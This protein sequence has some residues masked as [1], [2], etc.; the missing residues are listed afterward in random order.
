MNGGGAVV[1]VHGFLGA[2][3]DFDAMR[4]FL[5]GVRFHAVDLLAFRGRDVASLAD[6]LATVARD[7]G[8]GA[9]VGYSLG[10]RIALSLAASGRDGGAPCIALSA[11]PGLRDPGERSRRAADDDRLAALLRREGL[12]PF[13]ERWYAQPLFASLREHPDFPLIRDRRRRGDPSAWADLLAGC[14]P[15]RT[16]PAWDALPGLGG[17]LVVIAGERDAKYRD[18]AAEIGRHAPAARIE[19]IPEAGHALHLERPDALAAVLRPLL[20]A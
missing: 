20:T 6:E 1:L 10:G 12:G 14:S 8:A 9:I 11:H 5:P 17:R 7:V 19:V 18:L 15:G 13:I 16:P 2:P 4:S 3:E